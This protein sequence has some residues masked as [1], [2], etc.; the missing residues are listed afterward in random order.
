MTIMWIKLPNDIYG[1]MQTDSP[2]SGF[3]KPLEGMQYKSD[4]NFEA[5][6]EQ[7]SMTKLSS[8]KLM[9]AAI[10]NSHPQR[11]MNISWSSTDT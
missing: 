5:L 7:M 3:L 8:P 6:Q 2:E 10:D 4:K 1:Q 11:D 9:I